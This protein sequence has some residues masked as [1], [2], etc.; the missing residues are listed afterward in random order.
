MKKKLLFLKFLIIFNFL[1]GHCFYLS[2]ISFAQPS[3][4]FKEIYYDFGE[5][6]EDKL[7][8]H[9]FEFE[10]TG[11]EMLTISKVKPTCH[12]LVT[13]LSGGDFKPHEKG[14]IKI[15][16]QPKYQEGVQEETC[17]VYSND[18]DFP[19]FE[20]TVLAKVKVAVGAEPKALH[21]SH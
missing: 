6:K 10:N 14:Q 1:L 20:L 13:D 21:F 4:R 18:P 15:S 17:L 2:A 9:V 5:V 16:F 3:I 11:S 12:C 19:V 7:L 8:T